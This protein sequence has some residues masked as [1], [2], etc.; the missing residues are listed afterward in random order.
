MAPPMT[1]TQITAQLKKWGVNF[2][3]YRS[4]ATHNR[5]HK[6]PWGPVHGVLWHHTG[7][8]SKDQRNLLYS[9]RSDL[10]GP[11]CHF[12]VAQDGKVWLVGWGRANHAGEI[13]DD[14][15]DA[16]IEEKPLPVDN[17][18]NIDGNSRLYGIEIWYSGSQKMTAA[19]Y[20]S[21]L[22]ITAAIC[23]WHDWTGKS[24]LG[25][26][27][28]QPGKWDPGKTDMDAVRN[29]V[30]QFLADGAGSAMVEKSMYQKTLGSD[31][32][33]PPKHVDRRKNKFWQ[34]ISIIRHAA[35]QA[36]LAHKESKDAKVM[37][38]RNGKE[39]QELNKKVDEVL[40]RLPPL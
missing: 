22:L 9:G 23:D 31:Q 38:V 17:E 24:A 25:H 2:Q 15:L 7:S 33:T 32:A 1:A 28:V 37:A 39:L 12:G 14:V 27:E 30:S 11:L 34:P 8:D 13:D 18:A 26:G 21:S 5:N 36:Y 35:E 20:K 3:G 29:D 4:W 16:L 6:G 40:R 10:P 19:Q